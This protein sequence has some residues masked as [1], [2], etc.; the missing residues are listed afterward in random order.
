MW[1]HTAEARRVSVRTAFEG[2]M[3][4]RRL[5]HSGATEPERMPAAWELARPARAVALALEASGAPPSATDAE[6][7]RVRLGY[8]VSGD[9]ATGTV[10]VE[11]LGPPG[12]GAATG[13]E[14]AL[15]GC[16]DTL[17]SLGWTVLMYRGERRRR[18]LEVEVPTRGP[19][20]GR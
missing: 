20:A 6:G 11:W 13:E 12:S 7:R 10:R 15:G 2:L 5:S 1:G 19:G 9:V 14:S 4:I 8:A 16:A 17:R 18:F 3:Q